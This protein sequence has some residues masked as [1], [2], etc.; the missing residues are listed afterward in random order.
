MELIEKLGWLADKIPAFGDYG[1]DCSQSMR[2]AASEITELRQQLAAQAAQIEKMKEALRKS[3]VELFYCDQ[4]MTKT[5][6][7]DG[8]PMW[9]TGI[10]VSE[11][12]A[13]SKS[14]LESTTDPTAIL[15]E[16]DQRVAEACAK[17]VLNELEGFDDGEN[18]SEA[19]RSGEWKKYLP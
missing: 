8:E 6:D 3:Y 14:I 12:L 5:L 11:S 7:E 2:N 19:I 18:I 17:V 15:A 9:R 16:R 10:S 13:E 4:Q 1:K